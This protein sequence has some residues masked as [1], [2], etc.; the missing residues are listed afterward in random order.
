MK[1]LF[2]LSK[3]TAMVLLFCSM[4]LSANEGAKADVKESEN[5]FLSK[6]AHYAIGF[7]VGITH[8][9]DYVGSDETRTFAFPMPYI[10]YKN[11][12]FTL[13]RNAFEGN[14]FSSDKWH[15]SIDAAG[16]LP[17]KDNQARAGMPDL[18]WV[19]EFGTSLEYYI[20]GNHD[21]RNKL[22]IDWS[23]RKAIATDFT[24]IDNAGW[25]SQITLNQ[26]HV[27]NNKILGGDVAID[28]RASIIYNSQRYN[29]YFYGVS[30]AFQ[31]PNRDIYNAKSGYGGFRLAIGSTWRKDNLWFAVF[32]RYSNIN[33][34]TFETSSLVKQQHSLLA[35]VAFSYIFIEH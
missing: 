30:E 6:N 14:L 17:A 2:Q 34:A 22:F 21:S 9:N 26:N 23:V 16:S 24:G 3:S 1:L 8:L 28:A 13:D 15:L 10:Y 32:T 33:G 27:L 12:D 11:D 4:A 18:D 29:D 20:S 31:T 5:Y 7:G 19:G 25:V 35:G